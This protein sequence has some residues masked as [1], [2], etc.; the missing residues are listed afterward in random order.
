MA[1][2]K[3]LICLLRLANSKPLTIYSDFWPLFVNLIHQF[4]N[5]NKKTHVFFCHHCDEFIYIRPWNIYNF[6]YW[7]E[8]T[9]FATHISY[10]KFDL[11]GTFQGIIQICDFDRD[12]NG[13]IFIRF[14]PYNTVSKLIDPKD[15]CDSR[16]NVK[17]NGLIFQKKNKKIIN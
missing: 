5:H 1:S 6:H 3:E 8:K 17:I 12:H 9:P 2:E 7:H 14:P 4:F 11:G 13:K 10:I 15:R 16:K